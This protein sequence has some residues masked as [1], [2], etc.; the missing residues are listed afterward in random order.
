MG[1]QGLASVGFCVFMEM[2]K[3]KQDKTGLSLVLL[4][5][6]AF[7]LGSI[8]NNSTGAQG[9]EAT[10]VILGIWWVLG[11]LFFNLFNKN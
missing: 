6:V 9:L 7:F 10:A 3:S 1:S 8:I 11:I 4:L 2:N 5:V